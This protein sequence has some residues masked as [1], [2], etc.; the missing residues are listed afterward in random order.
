MNPYDPC[1]AN[2]MV[3]GNQMT[4][5]WHVN[6]VKS[7]HVNSKVNNSFIAWLKKEYGQIKEVKCSQGKK[8]NYLE[9][10][11]DYS[12]D[13]EVKIN[14]V[15]YVEKM[16]TKFPSDSLQ[17]SK[18]SSPASENLF[19]VDKRSPKLDAESAEMFHSFVLKGLFAAK[20]GRPDVL[21]Q[22]RTY[23]HAL[24]SRHNQIMTSWFEL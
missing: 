10:T 19:K 1:V 3:H 4:I 21:Q 23:V 9:M 20:R 8:H 6:D 22:S 24:K 5:M 2:K 18:V 15:D 14:R 17:G 12:V 13:G 7:S 11:L 16:V